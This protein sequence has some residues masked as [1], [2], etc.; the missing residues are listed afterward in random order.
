MASTTSPP[1]VG[2]AVIV[3]IAVV[4]CLR[5]LHINFAAPWGRFIVDWST[6]PATN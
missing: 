3:V 6:G 5:V 1:S 2:I 4:V